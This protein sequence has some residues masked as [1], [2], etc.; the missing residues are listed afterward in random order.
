MELFITLTRG[1]GEPMYGLLLS[2]VAVWACSAHPVLKV[3]SLD[4]RGCTV[5]TLLR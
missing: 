3:L 2:L 5:A 4:T 1:M